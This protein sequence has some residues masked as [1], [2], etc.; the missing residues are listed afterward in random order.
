MEFD[1]D[2][3]NRRYGGRRWNVMWPASFE[4]DGQVFP[5]TILDLSRTGARIDGPPLRATQRVAKIK[6]EQFG[7]LDV[8]VKW[9]RGTKSGLR[10]A[11][12]SAEIM[13]ILQRVVPGIGRRETPPPAQPQRAQFGRRRTPQAA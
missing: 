7:E 6:C 10:F 1:I 5:C 13:E 4:V 12:P 9:A 11:R 8:S 2:R 3:A